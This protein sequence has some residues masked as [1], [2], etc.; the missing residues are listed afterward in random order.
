M[1]LGKTINIFTI[2]AI[3]ISSLGLFG[4]SLF[5]SKQKTKEIGIRKV[6]GASILNVIILIINKF[7]VL[8]VIANIISWPIA[9]FIMNRWLQN[10]A[11]KT[12]IGFLVFIVAGLL[13]LIIVFA[14][15]IVNTL[16]AGRANPVEAL[17]YE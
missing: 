17:R 14:V 2:L 8:V 1:N 6:H 4:L 7:F 16:K 11:F 5:I 9:Y 10:F 12:N 15:L 13:S 3:F